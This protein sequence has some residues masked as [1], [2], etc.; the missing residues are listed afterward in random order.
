VLLWHAFLIAGYFTANLTPLNWFLLAIAP[1]FAWLAE[2]RPRQWPKSGRFS[3]R[4]GAVFI[5]M[6][7]AQF[8]AYH[9]FHEAMREMQKYEGNQ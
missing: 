2:F 8:L 4:F 9:D 3:L 1:H 6:L 5:P 7:L